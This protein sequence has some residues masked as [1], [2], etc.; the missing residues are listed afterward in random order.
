MKRILAICTALFAAAGVHAQSMT[1]S[2]TTQPCTNNGVCSVTVTGLTAPVSYTYSYGNYM[3]TVHS[4]VNSLTD[5]L[6]NLPAS[7]NGSIYI[8]ASDGTNSAYGFASSYPPFFVGIT[9]TPAICPS[10]TGSLTAQT[11]SGSPGPFT[12]SWVNTT[13]MA[14]YTGTMIIASIDQ[15]SLTVTDQVTGCF[16][17]RADSSTRI[18]QQSNMNLTYNSTP[19]NCTNGT[20]TVTASGGVAPYTYLWNNGA[21]SNTISGLVRGIYT[22]TVTDAQG[23]GSNYNYGVNIYQIPFINVNTSITNATCLQTNGGAM[24]FGT[25]G[26]SPYTYLWS[27]AQSTQSL[28]AVPGGINYQ[29]I[30]TD[31]NGCTGSGNAYISMTTPVMVSY[32][33][34]ASSC[35]VASGSASLSISGGVA[36]YTTLWNTY[37]TPTTGTVIS[38]V[39]PGQYSF[40][41]T[42]ANGCI[43]T[44][45]ALVPP[46]STINAVLSAPAVIC[47]ALTGTVSASVSGTNGPFTYTWSNSAHTTQISNVPL[48]TYSCIIK[49]AAGCSVTKYIGLLAASPVNLGVSATPA[50]CRYTS[51]GSVLANATGG[52]APYTYQWSNGQTTA[53]V[54]GLATGYLYVTATDANGC[55]S[56][57]QAFVGYNAANT[58]CYCTISGKVYRDANSNCTIDGGETGISNIMIH[59]SNFGYAFTDINGNYSFQVPTGTYTLSESVNSTYP[60]APCQGNAIV[61]SVT[62]GAG[63]NNI[64]NFANNVV[65]LHDLHII[66]TSFPFNAPIPGN[67]YYQKIIV[68]N[69]GTIPESTVQVGYVHDGQLGAFTGSL[70]TQQN[71]STYPNWYSI[72]SGFPT[73]N[74]GTSGQVNLT[75][76]VPT[77]IPLGTTVNFF[78][79]T[80]YASPMSTWLLDQTPWD[81][82]QNYQQTVIGSYDPNFK[83]VSPKGTGPQGYITTKDS[84]LSYVIHFQNEG[85]YFAQ[86]ISVL[87]SLDSDLDWTTLRPGYSDHSYTTTVN[88]NGVI[89]FKF[90]NINLPWKSQY[91]DLMSSGM[92]SY[93]IKRKRNLAQGTQF[94]NTAAI[95]FDYNAPVIT[96]TTLNTL[97]DLNVSIEEKASSGDENVSLFPNPATN[98]LNIAIY[99]KE[100]GKGDVYIMD[101]SGKILVAHSITVD[102]GNNTLNENTSALPSG[103]YFVKVNCKDIATTK[104]LVII[105]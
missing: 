7:T 80:A 45:A 46:S 86:N 60:L 83:E 66:T 44:G 3:T 18:S 102:A 9:N 39:S 82:V 35:T 13:T 73:L 74:P 37:P 27:N 54:S 48:G 40:K 93:T 68:E 89:T 67:P 43:R 92:V 72:L 36:P 96:N 4:N 5:Q 94:K 91:G 78:D 20:A 50:S 104:K 103:I 8:T 28:S 30:A 58:S 59:C 75:Y 64:V 98:A 95:Y 101:I 11:F 57:T 105:K 81:N 42:D 19:A 12:Y 29:V 53:T 88:E 99:V 32:N 34:T 62:A 77:N 47:P 55:K 85:T 23:C 16:V 1:A 79:T 25:G 41:V 84:L 22:A 21:V 6:T 76:N 61:Q 71:A 26:A 69:N 100:A 65:T 33:V 87:D 17:I 31:A 56:S 97:K 2:V 10:T 38:S 51:D 63:C 52:T 90:A 70:F 14:S 24:A 49:D 15:Y